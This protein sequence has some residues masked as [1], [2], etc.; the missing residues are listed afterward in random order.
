[1]SNISKIKVNNE[2]YDLKDSISRAQGYARVVCEWDG[3][4]EGLECKSLIPGS[5]DYYRV[6]DAV[7]LAKEEYLVGA[8]SSAYG[9]FLGASGESGLSELLFISVLAPVFGNVN[10]FT[11][12]ISYK[13]AYA[14]MYENLEKSAASVGLDFSALTK[15]GECFGFSYMGIMGAMGSETGLP[16]LMPHYINTSK[17]LVLPVELMSALYGRE[18]EMVFTPGLWLLKTD[19]ASLAGFKTFP[20]WPELLYIPSI[21]STKLMDFNIGK[22]SYL[23]ETNGYYVSRSSNGVGYNDYH[24][25]TVFSLQ[26][27]PTGP[28]YISNF[29]P[30]QIVAVWAKVQDGYKLSNVTITG[31]ETSETYSLVTEITDMNNNCYYCTFYMPEEDVQVYYTFEQI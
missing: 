3:I 7:E 12:G 22:L 25:T 18:E 5:L 16:G 14:K 31:Q 10:I 20:V 21:D 19:L 17:N 2:I 9:A 24:T 28:S 11:D 23:D 4:T 30:D 8:S 13:N 15:H 29:K 26:D 27:N 1:M 6:G